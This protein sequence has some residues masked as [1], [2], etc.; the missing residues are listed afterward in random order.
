MRLNFSVL[1]FDDDDD[2]FESI[3]DEMEDLKSEI[4]QWGFNPFITQVKTAEEFLLLSPF[5]KI[6]LIIVDRNLEQYGEGRDFINDLREKQIYTEII[7]NTAGKVS[8]LWDDIRTKELEGVYVSGKREIIPKILQVG[9]QSI[10]KVLDLENMRGI[11]MAEVGELDHLLDKI[12]DLGCQGLLPDQQQTIFTRFH[13]KVKEQDDGRANQLA[14]FNT[15]PDVAT[16]LPL[17]DSN[18]RWENFNRVKKYHTKLGT[19][20]IFGDYPTEILKP[21]NFLA[22]GKPTYQDDGT[23][24]FNFSGKTYEFDD[25]KSTQLRL[26]IITYKEELEKVMTLLTEDS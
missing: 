6:D 9:M 15:T 18:K 25:Q 20:L 24:L 21:R 22:H 2:Y 16:M 11:L 17:C 4:L 12:V 23:I 5:K 10:Q 7:F 3:Q 19:Q 13:A 1:W 14:Q 8:D 26:N